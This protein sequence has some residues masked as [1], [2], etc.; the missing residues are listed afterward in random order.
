MATAKEERQFAKERAK[1]LKEKTKAYKAAKKAGTLDARQLAPEHLRYLRRK[2]L[3]E[4]VWPICRLITDVHI[5]IGSER[6]YARR[7]FE[8]MLSGRYFLKYFPYFPE[9]TE[10]SVIE[11]MYH[12]SILSSMGRTFI[13]Y[14]F[15]TYGIC[16]LASP[17][18]TLF[19]HHQNSLQHA[20]NSFWSGALTLWQH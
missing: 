7:Y 18:A 17:F 19:K 3:L 5:L 12:E 1:H 9:L 13:S 11:P 8:Y 15:F 14:M 4:K 10:K 16:S 6:Q 20:A 2:R